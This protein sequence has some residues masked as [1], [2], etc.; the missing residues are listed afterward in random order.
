MV[1]RYDGRLWFDLVIR[2]AQ[3][4]EACGK[5]KGRGETMLRPGRA[6]NPLTDSLRSHERLCLDCGGKYPDA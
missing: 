2:R 1:A 3:V 4:C 6:L 5:V